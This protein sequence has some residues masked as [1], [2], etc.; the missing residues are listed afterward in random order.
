VLFTSPNLDRV[1]EVSHSAVEVVYIDGV[2]SV[3]HVFLDVDA[4]NVDTLAC[5]LWLVA[6]GLWLVACGRF[7]VRKY[8][9]NRSSTIFLLSFC[10]TRFNRVR[11]VYGATI[12]RGHCRL[13]CLLFVKLC[14][15]VWRF[16]VQSRVL[17]ENSLQMHAVVPKNTRPSATANDVDRVLEGLRLVLAGKVSTCIH[18]YR[19]NLGV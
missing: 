10:R 13:I 8:E 12:S 6:C 14:L 2:L 16:A 15:T 7:V 3:P 1:I 9:Y 19:E 18:C 5:G 4:L 17:V 11:L